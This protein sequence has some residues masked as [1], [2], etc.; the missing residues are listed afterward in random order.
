MRYRII[1]QGAYRAGP[2]GWDLCAEHLGTRG[3][4]EP[5]PPAAWRITL[6]VSSVT[7][8]RDALLVGT[9]EQPA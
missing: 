3:P 2:A 5:A 7:G 8:A 4:W 9:V 6:G 1:R